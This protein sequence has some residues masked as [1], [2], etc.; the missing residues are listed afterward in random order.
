MSEETK[1]LFDFHSFHANLLD[2]YSLDPHWEMVR[3][4]ISELRTVEML[5]DR[6]PVQLWK[7][8]LGKKKTSYFLFFKVNADRGPF[9]LLF[10]FSNGVST[11]PRSR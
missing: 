4:R 9:S 8:R 7:R 3:S 2:Y 1:L 6:K 11:C 5:F 10:L